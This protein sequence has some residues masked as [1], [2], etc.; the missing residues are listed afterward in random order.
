MKSQQKNTPAY[1]SRLLILAAVLVLTVGVAAWAFLS[2][3][4]N[5]SNY[6]EQVIQPLEAA[7]VN[8]GAV[9][10]CGYGD[11][12][13]GSDNQAPWYNSFYELPSG[14]D[15]AIETINRV[16]HENGYNLVHASKGNRGD[17]GAI[18]DA[19]ID[20]WY[21]DNTKGSSFSDLQSGTEKL[22][23]GV[24]NDGRHSLSNISCGTKDTVVINSDEKTTMISVSVKLPEF[25]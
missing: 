3:Q 19:Y 11:G 24:N 1:K 13:R 25:K 4:K 22:A 10:K 12:G 23:F 6:A 14:R 5:N 21:F 2:S 16:A 7:L 17:L 15:S 8:A 18:A 20:N 9:K